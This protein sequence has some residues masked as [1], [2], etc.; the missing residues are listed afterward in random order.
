MNSY[1]SVKTISDETEIS[2]AIY[3]AASEL[4][5]SQGS[6]IKADEFISSLANKFPG[7]KMMPLGLL[8]L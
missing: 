6:K 3:K 4:T 8:F 7:L 2:R 1:A 5:A